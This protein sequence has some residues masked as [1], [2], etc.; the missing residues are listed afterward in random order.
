MKSNIFVIKV[1]TIDIELDNEF[2]NSVESLSQNNKLW[3]QSQALI[4][5]R[6]EI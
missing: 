5:I 3:K 6:T 2:N 4:N 1:Y